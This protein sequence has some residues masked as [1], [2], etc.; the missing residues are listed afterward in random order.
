ML[1]VQ[2]A[3]KQSLAKHRTSTVSQENSEIQE[4]TEGTQREMDGSKKTLLSIVYWEQENRYVNHRNKI[5]FTSLHKT[6]SN[7]L[8]FWTLTFSNSEQKI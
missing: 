8:Q 3:N 2:E 5:P 7:K 6:N 1:K 4:V